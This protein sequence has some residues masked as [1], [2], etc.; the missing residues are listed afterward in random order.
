M[1]EAGI[2]H[3]DDR[4]EL[5]EGELI[6]MAAIGTRHFTSVNALNRLLTRTV[7]DEAIAAS[8]TRCASASITSRSRTWR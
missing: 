1:G 4:I 3:E 2:L 7:G 6:E 5:I 8:R